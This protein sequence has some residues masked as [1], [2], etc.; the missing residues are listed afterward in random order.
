MISPTTKAG[1]VVLQVLGNPQFGT[2]DAS[3][4]TTLADHPPAASSSSNSG[5]GA[6]DAVENAKQKADELGLD[7][8]ALVTSAV[9]SL[10]V[11]AVLLSAR[12]L[13]GGDD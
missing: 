7:G 11:G 6:K 12:H 1:R 8:T 13:L 10:V 9:A 2:Y 4:P 3:D 5:T